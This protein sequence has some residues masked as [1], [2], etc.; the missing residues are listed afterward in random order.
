MGEERRNKRQKEEE[1][2]KY[3]KKIA[4]VLKDL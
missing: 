1:M 3:K 4:D 2:V